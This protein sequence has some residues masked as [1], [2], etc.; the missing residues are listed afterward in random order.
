[1][2]LWSI[3]STFKMAPKMVTEARLI[4]ASSALTRASLSREGQYSHGCLFLA[5][6]APQ[7]DFSAHYGDAWPPL[8]E[9][10]VPFYAAVHGLGKSTGIVHASSVERPWKQDV[11]RRRPVDT[12][13]GFAC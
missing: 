12:S 13:A 11:V 5:C 6:E 9:V 10:G 8:L 3:Q 7:T 2:H 1:M 4:C